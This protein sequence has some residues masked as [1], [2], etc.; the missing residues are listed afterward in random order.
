MLLYFSLYILH[1]LFP[2]LEGL[3]SVRVFGTQY[4]FSH[5]SMLKMRTFPPFSSQPNLWK[6]VNK[7]AFTGNISCKS[8][9][10]FLFSSCPAASQGR[11]ILRWTTHRSEE[12]KKKGTYTKNISKRRRR[13][14]SWKING[15]NMRRRNRER[16]VWLV[17]WVERE[18]GED[19][20]V[21][22]REKENNTKERER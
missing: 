14:I 9:R 16:K 21:K 6:M 4:N 1:F 18:I 13:R 22:R 2:V 8:E 5:N 17:R 7:L 3:R 12:R 15:E 10:W 20:K 11:N 19:R